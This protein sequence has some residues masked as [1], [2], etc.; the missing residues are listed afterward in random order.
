MCEILV[1]DRLSFTREA[2]IPSLAEYL[3][4]RLLTWS[5][6]PVAE[7]CGYSHVFRLNLDLSA[8]GVIQHWC[9]E[10]DLFDLTALVLRQGAN[11]PGNGD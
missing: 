6:P 1:G 11:T 9:L 5:S 4:K 2:P 10:Y 8:L 3:A 7:T